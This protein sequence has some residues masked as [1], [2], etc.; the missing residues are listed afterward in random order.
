MTTF[1]LAQTAIRADCLPAPVAN[2]KIGDAM[3]TNGV[4]LTMTTATAGGMVQAMQLNTPILCK[5]PDGAL[6]LYTL[7]AER[8]TPTIPVLKPVV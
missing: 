7:D 2:Y 1:S 8:S 5:G 3:V 4:S 6:K